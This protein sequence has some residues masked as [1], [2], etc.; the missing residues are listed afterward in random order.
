MKENFPLDEL[1]YAVKICS[2]NVSWKNS[3]L[4][5]RIPQNIIKYCI[6]LKKELDNNKYKLSSY[7]YFN[8]YEPKFR[9]I[10][11][12]KFRDRV[13]QSMICKNGI[14]DD[15]M[16]DSIYN[17]CA[18]QNGKGT[19]FA[20]K[21]MN[22]LLKNHYKENKNNGYVLKLDI[23]KFF[24]SIPHDKLIQMTKNKI[25]ND[26]YQK[27]VI[28]LIHS[29]NGDVGIGLGS[30]IC[31]LLANSYL[32]RLDHYI[33]QK[34]K[35][36]SYIRYADDI[37]I[38]H[39]DKKYLQYCKKEIQNYLIKNLGLKL[40]KKSCLYPLS[41]GIVFL[42]MHYYIKDTGRIIRKSLKK[43]VKR[44]FRHFCKLLESSKTNILITNK[45]LQQSFQSWK[46]RIEQGH[47]KIIIKYMIRRIKP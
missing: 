14:Y 7:D 18:C 42:K 39:K 43:E 36:K 31:Q 4:K 19:T 15:L 33:K 32:N 23:H 13:V 26:I 17:S 35:I 28:E 21:R 3:V 8:I 16:K 27:L 34:L 2:R 11:S 40:N 12:L 5:W 37:V 38:I 20:I 10:L 1:I 6:A 30:Q 44:Y 25:K 45:Y 9:T 41:Q 46:S 29:F 22:L 47:N 24:D